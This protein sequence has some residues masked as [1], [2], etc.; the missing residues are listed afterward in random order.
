MQRGRAVMQRPDKK[1]LTVAPSLGAVWV[2]AWILKE[3][4]GVIMPTEIALAAG[5]VLATVV[6]YFFPDPNRNRS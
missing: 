4:T 6:G 5:G 2:L 3:A 1:I